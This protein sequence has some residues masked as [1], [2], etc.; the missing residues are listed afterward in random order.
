MTFHLLGVPGFPDGQEPVAAVR[1]LATVKYAD[2]PR[3]EYVGI[4]YDDPHVPDR[5]LLAALR[6]DPA[7]H[8]Y[9]HRS[10][11]AA[12]IVG[13]LEQAGYRQAGSFDWGD[14]AVQ[15]R[16]ELAR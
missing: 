13:V 10:D 2:D 14:D 7:V 8:N 6:Y 1:A 5:V 15:V 9:G 16:V 11:Y 12:E 4:E 3:G